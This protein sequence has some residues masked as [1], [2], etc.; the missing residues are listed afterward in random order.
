MENISCWEFISATASYSFP[1]SALQVHCI[2]WQIVSGCQTLL[3]QSS[4]SN[5]CFS[6]EAKYLSILNFD[7]EFGQ[8]AFWSKPAFL[9]KSI[10]K[11]I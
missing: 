10:W 11:S 1:G 6:G 9:W 3:T 2:I 4:H 7:L 5:C 8:T